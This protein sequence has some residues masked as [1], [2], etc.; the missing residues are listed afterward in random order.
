MPL[1]AFRL[2]TNGEIRVG[3]EGGRQVRLFLLQ[4]KE[5]EGIGVQAS[6]PQTDDPS[7][8]MTTVRY[9][10]WRGEGESNQF[11]ICQDGRDCLH[12]E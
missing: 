9:F 12:P 6:R 8:M 7:C 11:C 3:Q 1:V 2:A 4:E 10:M 5:T